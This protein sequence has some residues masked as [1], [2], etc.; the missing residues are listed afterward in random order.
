[1]HE[2]PKFLDQTAAAEFL[3]LSPRTLEKKRMDGEGPRYR[4]FGRRV[5][6]ELSELMEWAD[7]RIYNSTSEKRR[8][9]SR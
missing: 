7:E 5:L 3:G 9:E 8:E 4:K 1:M 2:S 6:Y